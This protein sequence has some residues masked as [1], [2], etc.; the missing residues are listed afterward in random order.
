M[1]TKKVKGPKKYHNA[2]TVVRKFA[3]KVNKVFDAKEPLEI[4]VTAE[5][6]ASKGRRDH[7]ECAMAV[8]LKRSEHATEV[9]MARTTAYVIKG[10]VAT[11][12]GVGSAISREVTAF[13]RGATFEPGKY[14]LSVPSWKLG[15][16]KGTKPHKSDRGSGIPVKK[17]F[18]H[19]TE[20]IRTTLTEETSTGRRKK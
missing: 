17:R 9:I 11:R 6:C 2:L 13:D 1:A 18:H 14:Q 15:S 12:Y 3:P 4:T 10:D 8:A 7:N 19:Y 16:Y 20:N 5:D